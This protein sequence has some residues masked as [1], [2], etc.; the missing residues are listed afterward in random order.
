MPDEAPITHT[1]AA[2]DSRSWEHPAD[3]AALNALRRLPAF[4]EVLKTIFGFFGEKPVRLAFQANAV[5][6][7]PTQFARVHHLYQDVARTLDA[8]AAFPV[9]VAQTPMVNAGAYGMERPFIIM[10][11]GTLGLLDDEELQ[12]ILGHELGHILSGHVL[13]TTMMVILVQLA[14]RGFPI[15]GLAARAILIALMEWYRKA[16][17]SA[18]RA[19]SLAVQRPEVGMRTMLKLAGGGNRGETNL[20][21]FIQQ[22]DEYRQGGDLADQVF[23]VLNVLGA[24]H[25]FPV[26]RVAE[27][28]DWFE[29]G[30][31]DRIVR[32]EYRRRGEQESPYTDDLGEAARSYAGDA[33]DSFDQA[34]AAARRV[35]DSFRE[36]FNRR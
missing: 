16:E 13:Y 27:L 6:V 11:S 22:A 20:P 12:F 5:R 30:E 9:F 1:L 34:A 25:P 17:L 36:G 29:A 15:V 3:R 4:D 26:I 35:V 23:K 2:I 32:G 10:N 28:R 19:G 7:S 21:E 31:Y 8:P 33:R 18:D 14:E 24:T